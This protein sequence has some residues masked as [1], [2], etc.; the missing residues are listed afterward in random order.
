MAIKVPQAMLH[1]KMFAIPCSLSN[2]R[3]TVADV[4]A[5]REIQDGCQKY[6]QG[7]LVNDLLY[8]F[9]VFKYTKQKIFISIIYVQAF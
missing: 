3:D 7:G 1:T 6:M 2:H 8:L 9:K 5:G 4:G